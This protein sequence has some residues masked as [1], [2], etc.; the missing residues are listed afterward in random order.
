MFRKTLVTALVALVVL[1]ASLVG[2]GIMITDDA[3]PSAGIMITDYAH[4][5][6][7]LGD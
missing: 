7:V 2:A 1:V 5:G 6:V 3:T 4:D